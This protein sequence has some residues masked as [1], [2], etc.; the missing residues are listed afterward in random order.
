MN[1]D[2]NARV[3][4]Y[5]MAMSLASEMR[6]KGI[7]TADEYAVIDTIMVKKYGLSSCTIYR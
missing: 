2:L 5:R 6:N 3:T 1:N 4:A 7:I